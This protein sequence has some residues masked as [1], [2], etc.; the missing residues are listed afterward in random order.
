MPGLSGPPGAVAA[1]PATPPTTAPTG[2]PTTAPATT[3]VAVP[4]LCC[5][6]WHAVAAR[7]T[8]AAKMSLRIG[9]SLRRDAVRLSTNALGDCGFAGR[10]WQTL[11]VNSGS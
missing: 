3:P 10:G 7:Q 9:F 11:S 5:G 1:A 4:A 2:P 8:T 6:V